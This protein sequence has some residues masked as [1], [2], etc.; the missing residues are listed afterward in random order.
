[1][2]Y[3]K[4]VLFIFAT[5]KNPPQSSLCLIYLLLETT[6]TGV[7]VLAQFVSRMG[8]V[9]SLQTLVDNNSQINRCS[10]HRNLP[11]F[12]LWTLYNHLPDEFEFKTF[13]EYLSWFL[14]WSKLIKT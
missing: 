1:M 7:H 6:R 9:C 12:G 5:T 11:K 4:E 2:E 3:I 13:R 8:P 14:D 10:F